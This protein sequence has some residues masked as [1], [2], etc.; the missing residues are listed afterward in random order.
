MNTRN[1]NTVTVDN[2]KVTS[3]DLPVGEV[4]TVA[5]HVSDKDGNVLEGVS[6]NIK[7]AEG[8]AEAVALS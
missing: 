6:V 2:V 3:Y 8:A 4:E 5:G 7:S 1:S